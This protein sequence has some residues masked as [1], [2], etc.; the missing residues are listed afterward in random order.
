M[1]VGVS[2]GAVNGSL[3][4]L[5]WWL[6]VA[7]KANSIRIVSSATHCRRLVKKKAI[8]FIALYDIAKKPGK[9]ESAWWVK[10]KLLFFLSNKRY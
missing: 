7:F 4:G 6:L 8:C 10:E 2:S 5:T 3:A 1:S 9:A